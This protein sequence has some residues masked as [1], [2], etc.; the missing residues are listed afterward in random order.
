MGFSPFSLNRINWKLDLAIK[1]PDCGSVSTRRS[2]SSKWGLHAFSC[3]FPF[4]CFIH[5]FKCCTLGCIKLP[6][7]SEHR[8]EC[9]IQVFFEVS[10][11]ESRISKEKLTIRWSFG[12]IGFPVSTKKDRLPLIQSLNSSRFRHFLRILEIFQFNNSMVSPKTINDVF[13]TDSPASTKPTH[14]TWFHQICSTCHLNLWSVFRF[15]I[16]TLKRW[17]S[18]GRLNCSYLTGRRREWRFGIFEMST[19]RDFQWTASR[20]QGAFGRRR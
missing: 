6:F 2:I 15:G 20:P 19:R 16:Q 3:K 5:S 4:S 18:V 1:K 10:L 8:T 14:E 9:L 13:Q 17:G 11:F 12:R 7:I